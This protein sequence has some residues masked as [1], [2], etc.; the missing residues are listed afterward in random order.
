MLG[1]LVGVEKRLPFEAD[2]LHASP[3]HRFWGMPTAGVDAPM[4]TKGYAGTAYH[5]EYLSPFS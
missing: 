5:T 1:W 3:V 4:S 2:F